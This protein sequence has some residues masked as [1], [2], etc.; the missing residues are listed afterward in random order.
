LRARTHIDACAHAL[1]TQIVGGEALRNK[2]YAR[3]DQMQA[4][5]SELLRQAP[6]ESVKQSLAEVERSYALLLSEIA[7]AEG[8]YLQR[9]GEFFLD[10]K[11]LNLELPVYAA[12]QKAISEV[13][14]TVRPCKVGMGPGVLLQVTCVVPPLTRLHKEIDSFDAYLPCR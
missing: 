6:T 7:F 14:L 8:G 10:R 4:R 5:K 9:K 13:T 1:A 2:L 12:V 11:P 3:R